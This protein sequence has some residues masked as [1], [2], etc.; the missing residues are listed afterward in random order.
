V[1]GHFQVLEVLGGFQV[2]ERWSVGALTSY[3]F[4]YGKLK[5]G[6]LMILGT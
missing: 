5:K 2:L 6:F 3:L 4:L 1:K